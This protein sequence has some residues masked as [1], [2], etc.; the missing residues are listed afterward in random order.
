MV[1]HL[2][3]LRSGLSENFAKE[4]LKIRLI[5]NTFPVFPRS[6]LSHPYLFSFTHSLYKNLKRKNIKRSRFIKNYSKNHSWKENYR[7]IYS[8]LPQIFQIKGYKKFIMLNSFNKLFIIIN[9]NL[10]RKNKSYKIKHY[11]IISKIRIVIIFSLK[12]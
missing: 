12:T 3:H 2:L 7:K 11:W 9:I 6:S 8:F 5:L 4:F 1:C 10:L